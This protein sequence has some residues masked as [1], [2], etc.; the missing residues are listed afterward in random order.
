MIERKILLAPIGA[1]HGIKGDVRVK[2][3]GDPL[4][5]DQYGKLETNSG[6]KLKITRMRLQKNV[7][8]VKFEGIN[9]REEAEVLRNVELFVE[10]SKLPVPEEEEFYVSD[11]IGMIAVNETG[12][13]VGTVK[14]VPNFGA[15]DMLEISPV[16]GG[17]TYYLPFTQT[18]VPE[19]DFEAGQLIIV[20]PDEV[21]ERDGDA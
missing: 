14:G 9:S 11:L 10:R 20:P 15:G 5:L 19:I 7:L 12:A 18:V 1:A 17:T 13:K 3:F 2:P 4:M 6:Q 21:S 16:S 8:I